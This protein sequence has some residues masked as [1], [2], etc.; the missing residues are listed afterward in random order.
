MAR[1][2]DRIGLIPDSVVEVDTEETTK[3]SGD[4]ARAIYRY[5]AMDDD[6]LSIEVMCKFQPHPVSIYSYNAGWRYY[7][8]DGNGG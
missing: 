7:R 3:A 6:E 8:G 4:I 2:G 5:K 1:T